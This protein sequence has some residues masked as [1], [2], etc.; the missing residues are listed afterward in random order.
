MQRSPHGE[1]LQ[2]VSVG[3]GLVAREA[4]AANELHLMHG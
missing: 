1:M 4:S 2:Q 3:T